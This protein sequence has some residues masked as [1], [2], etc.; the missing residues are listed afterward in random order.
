MSQDAL[1]V[2]DLRRFRATQL[3][4]PGATVDSSPNLPWSG[5]LEKFAMEQDALR[6][7]C[8]RPPWSRLP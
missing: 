1:L 2:P 6:P 5:T 7:Q 8:S 4:Y 3:K